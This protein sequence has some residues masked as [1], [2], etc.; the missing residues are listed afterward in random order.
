MVNSQDIRTLY[1]I[2][3]CQV[4]GESLGQTGRELSQVQ[5]GT[6]MWDRNHAHSSGLQTGGRV[7]DAEP[8]ALSA[9]VGTA[10]GHL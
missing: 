4:P 7:E 8:Q 10:R 3:F 1:A 5:L 9:Q 6:G 2:P